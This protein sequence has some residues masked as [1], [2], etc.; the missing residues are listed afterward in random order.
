[1]P[2]MVLKDMRPPK[3]SATPSQTQKGNGHTN[4]YIRP[5]NQEI[6]GIW[7]QSVREGKLTFS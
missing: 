3:L 2:K 1:M 7:W 5:R 6:S 4:A